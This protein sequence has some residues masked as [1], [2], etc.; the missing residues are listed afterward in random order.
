MKLRGRKQNQAL[1]SFDPNIGSVETKELAEVRQKMARLVNQR[2]RAIEK[3]KSKVTGESLNFGAIDKLRLYLSYRNKKRFSERLIP[4][5]VDTRGM[6]ERLR[7]EINIM[8]AFLKSKSST[9]TGLRNIEK[10]RIETFKNRGIKFANT[11]EFYD[12]LNSSTY[13]EFRQS[14]FTSEQIVDL[15]DEMRE[16]KSDNEVNEEIQDLLNIWRSGE[17]KASIK[18]IKNRTGVNLLNGSRGKGTV[19]KR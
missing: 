5:D 3:A 14:G 4:P 11:K 7:K 13:Q 8:Q 9:I 10:R 6:R 18:S 17:E 2:M 1:L 16:S 19:F 15:Y 12:F